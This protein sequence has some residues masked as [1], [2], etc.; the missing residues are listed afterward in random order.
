MKKSKVRWFNCSNILILTC[1]VLFLCASTAKADV[2]MPSLFNFFS[3]FH[4]IYLIPV[5]LIE[6]TIVYILFRMSIF[7]KDKIKYWYCLLMIFVAN[8]LTTAI[9]IFY[10][11]IDSALHNSYLSI[12]LMYITTALIE[13]AVIFLFVRKKIKNPF[14]NSL[15]LSFFVNIFSYLFLI[16]ISGTR[17]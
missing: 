10:P 4:L 1:L 3:L 13:A 8:I 17:F 9:G 12:I 7:K 2:I 16:I 15:I 5:V 11:T 6:A 14:I